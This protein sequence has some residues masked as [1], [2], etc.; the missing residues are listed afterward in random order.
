MA[1]IL[2]WYQAA[3]RG[4][5][6]ITAHLKK[7]Q[8]TCRRP[9]RL[10]PLNDVSPQKRN[11]KRTERPLTYFERAESN[12]STAIIPVTMTRFIYFLFLRMFKTRL[13]A[14][15]G[16]SLAGTEGFSETKE[17]HNANFYLF[18][19]TEHAYL[20]DSLRKPASLHPRPSPPAG[21]HTYVLH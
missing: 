15:L 6:S 18:L 1:I 20:Q 9:T 17:R 5:D 14:S 21:V 2:E 12:E 13:L 7:S 16:P 3:P 11:R 19:L 10:I 4:Y 8:Q